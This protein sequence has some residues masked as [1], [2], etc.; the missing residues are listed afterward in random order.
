M[1]ASSK[2][3]PS[4]TLPRAKSVYNAQAKR[5]SFTFNGKEKDNETY[6]EGNAYDFGARVYDARLGKWMSVD[7]LAKKYASESNYIFC[8]NNP[9]FY[10]DKLGEVKITYIKIIHA[11]NSETVLNFVDDK[12]VKSQR[13]TTTLFGYSTHD[14]V[15]V[16][17]DLVQFVTINEET[18]VIQ[19]TPEIITN[20]TKDMVDE[21]YDEVVNFFDEFKSK[22]NTKEGGIPMTASEEFNAAESK[23]LGNAKYTELP[24]NVEALMM[25]RGGASFNPIKIT[26][27]VPETKQLMIY[28][29]KLKGALSGWDPG[30]GIGDVINSATEAI[31]KLNQNLNPGADSCPYCNQVAPKDSMKTTNQGGTHIKKVKTKTSQPKTTNQ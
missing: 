22:E 15:D 2:Y 3:T 12:K 31:K 8:S 17:Y 24:I 27:M 13:V 21:A 19:S 11:D 23:Y 29:E 16:D 6:G 20:P 14:F 26:G 4:T 7:P 30:T 18:G 9:I 28:A 25:A 1:F 5:Y 10:I